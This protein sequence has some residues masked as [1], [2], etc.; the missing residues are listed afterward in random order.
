[1]TKEFTFSVVKLVEDIVT[2]YSDSLDWEFQVP[3]DFFPDPLKV[4]IDDVY[5]ISIK[6]YENQDIVTDHNEFGGYIKQQKSTK[7][8][9]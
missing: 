6:A 8:R 1:M 7:F 9:V 4:E 3:L 5:S 2:L